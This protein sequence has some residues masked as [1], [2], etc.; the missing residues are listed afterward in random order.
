MGQTGS[1]IRWLFALSRVCELVWS[2]VGNI[3]ER[4]L[5]AEEELGHRQVTKVR[6]IVQDV[7]F[8]RS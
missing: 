1:C 5:Q 4:K 3:I 2:V 8:S 7:A 6:A